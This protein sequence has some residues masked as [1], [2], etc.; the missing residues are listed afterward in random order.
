MRSVRAAAQYAE[1]FAQWP[2]ALAAIESGAVELEA[3]GTLANRWVVSGVLLLNSSL[4]LTRFQREGDPHQVRGHLPL[5]RPL[6]VRVLGH[7]AAQDA[8]VV[9]IGFGDAAAHNVRGNRHDYDRWAQMGLAGWSYD[10]VLPV[11]RRSEG[12]VHRDGAYHG[13]TGELTVCRARGSNPLFDA[14]I[15]AGRQAGYPVIDDFNG[16]EQQGFGRYDFT[17]SSSAFPAPPR[18]GSSAWIQSFS[19]I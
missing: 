16:P 2:A 9:F 12:H 7:L 10:D 1:G 14:F 15:E 3:P 5:W 19:G 18:C 13:R 4:T 17:I 8:P 6:M 11:F